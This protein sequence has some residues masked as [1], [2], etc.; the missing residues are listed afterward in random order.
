M[1]ASK[2][3]LLSLVTLILLSANTDSD[4]SKPIQWQR[5]EDV[6]GVAQQPIMIDMYTEWCGWCKR[7]DATTFKDPVVA[8]Y[9]NETFHA[10]KFDA[11]QKDSIV[12]KEYVYKYVKQGRRGYNEL[13]AALL[14]GKMSYPT[15]VFLDKN[16]NIITRVPGYQSARD[17][18]TIVHFVGEEAYRTTTWESFKTEYNSRK[19]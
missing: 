12:F 15:V 18:E 6:L 16:L 17:F 10:V 1:N 14:D 2:F 19:N 4:T 11:E 8:D 3:G 7:M 13:A 5:I 9:V